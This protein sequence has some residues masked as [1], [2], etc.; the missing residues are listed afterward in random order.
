[1]RSSETNRLW[2][3]LARR[4][5]RSGRVVAVYLSPDFNNLGDGRR[6]IK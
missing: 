3:R 2:T 1:M 6:G 5:N 4:R